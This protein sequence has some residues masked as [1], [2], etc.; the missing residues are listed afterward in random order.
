VI[1]SDRLFLKAAIDLAMQGLNTCAPNPAVGC[2]IVRH[3]R[4]IGRGYHARTGSAHAEVNAIADAGGDV[5]G[6]TVYVS[7]EP[8]A[9]VGRT[10]ACAQTLIDAGVAR[11]VIAAEDPHPQVAG[12]G[13]AMLRAAG[14]EVALRLQPAALTLLRGYTSR[15]QRARPW[16]RIKTASSMDGATALASGESKWITGATARNDVQR[17]RAR[18]DAIITGVGTVLADDPQLN[19][20]AAECLPCEQPLRV[21]LDRRLRTPAHAKV[22]T[23]G[24]ATLLVHDVAT[25]VPPALQDRPGVSFAALPVDDSMLGTLLE[26]L[27]Q[28]GCNEVLVE[29]GARLIGSFTAQRLWDEWLCYLAPSWLGNDTRRLAS[30]QLPAL[31][32][33]PRGEMCDI[34]PL[35]DDVLVRLER[36]DKEAQS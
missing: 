6:A 22:V 3:G 8:C 31:A 24:A 1:G 26:I 12:A 19:V 20:R 13:M 21:I 16:V 14:I 17:W 15:I 30:F 5:T 11:V 36:A 35:G 18:S 2:V 34:T 29:A 7:L 10:P 33:A 28:R 32:Q 25:Q 4:I 23:D 27:A 9:F